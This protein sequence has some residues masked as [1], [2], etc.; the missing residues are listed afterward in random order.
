MDPES[1]MKR[2]EEAV[3]S[4]DSE[5]FDEA[6]EDFQE[7]ANKG[8]FVTDDLRERLWSACAKVLG[9]RNELVGGQE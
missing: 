7:W 8:G 5:D 9:K 3:G 2:I 4:T 6:V 1:C